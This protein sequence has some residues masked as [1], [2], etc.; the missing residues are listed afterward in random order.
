MWN[1]AICPVFYIHIIKITHKDVAMSLSF[2]VTL[3]IFAPL[4][5]KSYYEAT[6]ESTAT[7][8]SNTTVQQWCFIPEWINAVEW[9]GWVND[10]N[11]NLKKTVFSFVFY[12]YFYVLISIEL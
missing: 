10:S 7:S 8:P 12:I 3:S 6:A 4:A 5:E 11:S 1:N 2:P 9:I